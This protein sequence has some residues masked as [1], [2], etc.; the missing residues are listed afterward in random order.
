MGGSGLFEHEGYLLMAA[1]F[2]VY[3]EQ[4]AG[5]GEDIYQESLEIELSRRE[6]PFEKQVHVPVFYKGVRL[7]KSFIPDLLVVNEIIVELKAVQ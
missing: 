7:T 4:G 5:F 2:A 6:I 3:N 1:A